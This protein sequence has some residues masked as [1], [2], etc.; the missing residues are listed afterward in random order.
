MTN[1][2]MMIVPLLSGSGMRIKIIE[3]MALG[4]TVI[5]TS[6]GAEGIDYTD[7]E[8]II[9]CDDYNEFYD[10]IKSLINST[11]EIDRIGSN[12]RRLVEDKYN[13]KKVIQK[14]IAFYNTL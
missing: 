2:D 1:Y 7:G 12:A 13:N 11:S 10:R 5:S 4:K 8:N 9:I 3:G 14:L 6:I